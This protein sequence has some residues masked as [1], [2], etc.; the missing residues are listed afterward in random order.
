MIGYSYILYNLLNAAKTK[1]VSNNGGK[2]SVGVSIQPNKKLWYPYGKPSD[3]LK[4]SS[5]AVL[6]NLFLD[7]SDKGR[8]ATLK[9]AFKAFFFHVYQSFLWIP[10][11]GQ[12]QPSWLSITD[13]T[14]ST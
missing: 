10:C 13:K 9:S 11:F 6:L 5:A 12:Y 14:P 7:S 2:L 3:F 8:T 1:S 4:N